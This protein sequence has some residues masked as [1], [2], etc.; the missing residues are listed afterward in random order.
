MS[1]PDA[2]IVH[3]L[4]ILHSVPSMHCSVLPDP[5]HM[6][7]CHTLGRHA[8]SRGPSQPA[9]KSKT[10]K[11][12]NKLQ[13][14]RC[15]LLLTGYPPAWL[16]A[17][18]PWIAVMLPAR[19]CCGPAACCTPPRQQQMTPPAAQ[20]RCAGSQPAA[21]FS[22]AGDRHAGRVRGG[23]APEAASPACGITTTVVRLVRLQRCCWHKK[24]FRQVSAWPSKVH[25]CSCHQTI[26]FR[27]TAV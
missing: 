25:Q 10:E 20:Q 9:I 27:L 19:P 13:G 5:A 8:Q 23:P 1:T 2:T 21:Q 4:C 11:L 18:G 7:Q 12:H 14:S 15:V 17:L 24:E 22:S 6:H 3:A 26:V 16:L